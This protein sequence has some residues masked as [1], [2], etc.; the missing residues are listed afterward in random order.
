M[1]TL[2][3]QKKGATNTVSSSNDGY[4]REIIMVQGNSVST[5]HFQQCKQHSTPHPLIILEKVEAAEH[6]TAFHL[7]VSLDLDKR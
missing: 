3:V 4:S 2:F 6:G 1:L 7:F 5:A